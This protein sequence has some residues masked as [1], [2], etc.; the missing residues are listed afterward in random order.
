LAGIVNLHRP[1]SAQQDLAASLSHVEHP[2][3]DNGYTFRFAGRRYRIMRQD[4]KAGM[5]R[6][7]LRIELRLSGE[8][9][10]RYEGRYVEI[11]ECDSESPAPG[12]QASQKAVRKDHNAGGKSHWMDGFFERPGPELWQAVEVSN[13]RN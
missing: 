4:V 10:A 1:L 5:R 13:A 6:Q 11:D 2:V 7:R 8:I 3:M 12:R 9:K